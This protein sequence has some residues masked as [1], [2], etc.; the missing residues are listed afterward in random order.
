VDTNGPPCGCGSHGCL[1]TLVSG[2]ALASEGVRLL[3]SGQAPKLFDIVEGDFGKVDARTM[4]LAARAGEAS[5][6]KAIHRAAT[7]LGVAVSNLVVSIDPELVVIGGGVAG[8][9][10]LLMEPL[11]ETVRETVRIYPTNDLRIEVSGV[12][13]GAGVMGA[14][15]LAIRGGALEKP[16]V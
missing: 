6:R 15:A 14:L 1:E 13:E 2:P 16:G 8:L 4:G 10:D 9:G 11:R 5:V 12:G 3:R 7:Y